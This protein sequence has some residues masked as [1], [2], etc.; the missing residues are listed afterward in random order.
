[1]PADASLV[2][3]VRRRCLRM[4]ILPADSDIWRT[5]NPVRIRT[6]N[7]T[8]GIARTRPMTKSGRVWVLFVVHEFSA[9]IRNE[10]NSLKTYQTYFRPIL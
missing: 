6:R 7:L 10:L 5:F 2:K 1:M 4:T 3:K 8:V 9:D